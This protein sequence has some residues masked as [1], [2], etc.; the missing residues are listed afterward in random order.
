MICKVR[1]W[2]QH[3]LVSQFEVDGLWSCSC[4][5]RQLIFPSYLLTK[6]VTQFHET[7]E[8]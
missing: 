5:Q 4:V 1:A 6:K 3:R 2:P 7:G 8:V